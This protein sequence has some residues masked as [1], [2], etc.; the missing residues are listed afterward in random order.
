MTEFKDLQT[1]AAEMYSDKNTRQWIFTHT[2][3]QDEYLRVRHALKV[4][5]EYRPVEWTGPTGHREPVE[6]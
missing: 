2:Y 1:I 5:A 3:T 4:L 6:V